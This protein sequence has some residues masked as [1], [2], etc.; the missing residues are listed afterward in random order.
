M[1]FVTDKLLQLVSIEGF[2]ERLL[3]N[4]GSVE[5]R[6]SPINK[7]R[8]Y[9][10][11]EKAVQPLGISGRRFVVLHQLERIARQ[12]RGPPLTCILAQSCQRSLVIIIIW[13]G[14]EELD[15]RRVISSSLSKSARSFFVL[16]SVA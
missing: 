6:L 2:A 14:A 10:T 3:T 1:N 5:E 16:A 4:E 15:A 8:E 12:G 7:P 9:L 11:F 13:L